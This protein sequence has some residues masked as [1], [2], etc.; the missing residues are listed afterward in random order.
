MHNTNLVIINVVGG[1]GAAA[2]GASEKGKLCRYRYLLDISLL[3]ILEDVTAVHS[4]SCCCKRG[5]A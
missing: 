2:E 1:N 5:P 4:S 3:K